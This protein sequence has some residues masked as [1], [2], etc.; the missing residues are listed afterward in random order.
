MYI[1]KLQYFNELLINKLQLTLNNKIKFI[2]Y[3]LLIPYTLGS[4]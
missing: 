2:S 4:L 1:T 3:F